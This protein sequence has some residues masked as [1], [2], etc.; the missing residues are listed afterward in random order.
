[1]SKRQRIAGLLHRSGVL[2]AILALRA[3][4]SS[5]WLG[6]LTYHRFPSAGPEL[7][8]DG[9]V[10][11]TDEDFDA[12]I[13]SLQRHFTLLGSEELCAIALGAKPPPNPMAITFDDGYR[14]CYSRALPILRRHDAKA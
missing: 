5:G 7:F 10:D 6:I 8:D 9:V 3:S 2:R 1:M 11:T 13:P 14:D 12:L 4:L